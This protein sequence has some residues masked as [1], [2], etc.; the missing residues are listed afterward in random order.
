MSPPHEAGHSSAEQAPEASE[1]T[2]SLLKIGE[3]AEQLGL[4]VRTIRF[5]EEEGLV[6]PATRTSGGFRLYDENAVAS[7][8]FIKQMKPLGFSVEDMG[9]VLTA[10]DALDDP[11]TTTAGRTELVA[12]LDAHRD[13]VEEKAA[14]LLDKAGRGR[15]LGRHLCQVADLQM[16]VKSGAVGDPRRDGHRLRASAG[17]APA[18]TASRPGRAAAPTR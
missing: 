17:S 14:D 10:L 3:V 13:R 16:R 1:S 11:A 4:S 6:V 5:Y 7:L 15:E 12:Q 18:G 9:E 2:A 8:Q